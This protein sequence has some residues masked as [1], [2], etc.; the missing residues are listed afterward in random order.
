MLSS[1]NT[2]KSK[3]LQR[4]VPAQS[5]NL[6][7]F[8]CIPDSCLA[9]IF[10]W[11]GPRDLASTELVARESKSQCETPW[12]GFLDEAVR[13]QTPASNARTLFREQ[14]SLRRFDYLHLDKRG[15]AFA[16]SKCAATP[17]YEL[18]QKKPDHCLFHFLRFVSCLFS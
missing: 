2:K 1:N 16:D 8:Q 6:I 4:P 14:A 5:T 15:R 9:L 11:L 7:L 13:G 10:A 3:L 12:L 18:L 17:V